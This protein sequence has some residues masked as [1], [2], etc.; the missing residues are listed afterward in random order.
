MQ[1]TVR[2]ARPNVTLSFIARSVDGDRIITNDTMTMPEGLGYTTVVTTSNVFLYSPLLVL[3]VCTASS[4]PGLLKHNY[5]TVLVENSNKDISHVKAE[6]IYIKRD[7]TLKLS[8]SNQNIGY[9]VWKKS[10]PPNYE[11][12]EI[13]LHSVFI[14]GEFTQI[15]ADDVVLGDNSS[16]VIYSSKVKHEGKYMCISG[17]GRTN[18]VAVYNVTMIGK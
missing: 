14:G 4:S 11:E 6:S 16:L 12:H 2:R 10:N 15:L 13:L 17:D 7:T 8:C 1:C 5:S 18:G 3:L 9:F